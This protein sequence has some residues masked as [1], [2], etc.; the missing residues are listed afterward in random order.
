[1]YEESTKEE[2]I[3]QNGDHYRVPQHHVSDHAREK[4]DKGA[5]G[6]EGGKDE[7]EKEK[8]AGKAIG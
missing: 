3:G 8:E 4:C 2:K 6:P 7:E 5:S 1:M